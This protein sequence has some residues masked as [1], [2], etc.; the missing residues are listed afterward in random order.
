M[1]S[2]YSN[3]YSQRGGHRWRINPLPPNSFDRTGRVRASA[4]IFNQVVTD[5]QTG[6]N[7]AV[8]ASTL[9][10]L[11]TYAPTGAVFVPRIIVSGE[12]P[13]KVTLVLNTATIE[14]RRL[15]ANRELE[16]VFKH[17]LGLVSGDLLDVKVQHEFTGDT[18]EFETTLH[19]I[20][21]A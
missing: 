18:G 11:L 17:P 3:D 12:L 4:E 20:P 13:A 10:T 19:A 1:P 5:I 6:S 7:P 2:R 15:T 21:G 14:T 9:T 16:F 8:S